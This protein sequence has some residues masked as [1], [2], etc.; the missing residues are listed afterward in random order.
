MRLIFD[1]DKSA[2]TFIFISPPFPNMTILSTFTNKLYLTQ[3]Q[4]N[5]RW[6]L[7]CVMYSIQI[8][9]EQSGMSG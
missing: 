9:K 3:S 2:S 4:S 1:S 7:F 8:T 6:L 5:N